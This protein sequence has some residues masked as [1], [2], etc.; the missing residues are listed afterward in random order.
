MGGPDRRH[1]AHQGTRETGQ[2]GDLPEIARTHLHHRRPL[3]PLSGEQRERHADVIVERPPAVDHGAPGADGPG[4]HVLGGGLAHRSGY[5]HNPVAHSS[6]G[7]C[8]QFPESVDGVVNDHLR[9]TR[10]RSGSPPVASH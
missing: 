7:G 6:T 2:G 4:Q 1:H 3:P 8:G 9:Q 10:S 5:P